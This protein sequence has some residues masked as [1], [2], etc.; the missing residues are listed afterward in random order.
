VGCSEIFAAIETGE[1]RSHPTE[2]I[3][4]SRTVEG[5]FSRESAFKIAGELLLHRQ[6]VARPKA[7]INQ[8]VLQTTSRAQA[9]RGSVI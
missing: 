9:Q 2:K 1:F 7:A 8:A 3:S 5:S 4:P 6:A